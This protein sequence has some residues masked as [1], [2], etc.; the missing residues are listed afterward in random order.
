[1]CLFNGFIFINIVL[2]TPN[3][4]LRFL[5]RGFFKILFIFGL[6]FL[7]CL[8]FY[9]RF[10][11]CIHL[12]GL[13]FNSFFVFI[14]LTCQQ[15]FSNS[16]CRTLCFL[17]ALICYLSFMPLFLSFIINFIS[18]FFFY[19]FYFIFLKSFF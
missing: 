11:S 7:F 2:F 18:S 16:F 1:M 6:F 9:V 8:F 4:H 15:Q 19:Y 13:S 14:L 10:F 12:S 17:F 5:N 3:T